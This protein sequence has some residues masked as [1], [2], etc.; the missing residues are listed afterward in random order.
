MPIFYDFW[1]LLKFLFSGVKNVL[2]ASGGWYY[3][4]ETK[5]V[6]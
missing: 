4:A 1:A 2:G 5:V 3:S 6:H